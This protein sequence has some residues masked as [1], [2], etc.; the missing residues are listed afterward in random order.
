M[1]S[2]IDVIKGMPFTA[3]DLD[4]Y[5][6]QVNEILDRL[7]KL[8]DDRAL[9]IVAALFVEKAIDDYLSSLIPDYFKNKITRMLNFFNKIELA[10]SFLLCPSRLINQA[11]TIREIRNE[12]AHNIEINKINEL[13]SMNIKSL[14][15]ILNNAVGG[16]EY[17]DQDSIT[18][19]QQACT[20][21]ILNMSMRTR[22][23][24]M[25]NLYIRSKEFQKDFYKF[26]GKLD[27]S[28][29]SK[30]NFF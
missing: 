18:I 26:I 10:R 11:H 24:R 12:F 30:F 25:I 8:N 27:V 23:N 17:I 13:K 5:V 6:S 9:V 7:G 1:F 3:E 22:V 19:F 16:E 21:I 20:I 4:Q 29:L 2:E 14:K 15:K 28:N